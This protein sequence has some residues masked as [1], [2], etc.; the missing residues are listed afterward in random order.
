MIQKTTTNMNE[1][2][3]NCLRGI[4]PGKGVLCEEC[5]GTGLRQ[6]KKVEAPRK[7]EAKSVE[8]EVVKKVEIKKVI[9]KKK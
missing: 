9:K 2:C 4:V 1:P 5:A 8:K 7:A 3:N 6:E